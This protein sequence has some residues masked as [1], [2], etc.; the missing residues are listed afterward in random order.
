MSFKVL[1]NKSEI[2]TSRHILKSRKISSLSPWIVRYLSKYNITKLI[3]IG[4]INKS[5]DILQT[6][7]FIEKNCSKKA[8]ILDLGAFGSEILSVL[9]NLNYLSLTGIDMNKQISK[10]PNN[11]NITYTCENYL[12]SSFEDDSFDVV[13]AISAIEHGFDGDRL[14][15]EIS[16]ILRPGGFFISSFDYWPDKLD[17][18]GLTIFN[19]EWTIFSKDEVI[20]FIN[21]S[22]KYNFIPYGE[23]YYEAGEKVIHWGGKEYTFG[24][25]ALLK[26]N[27][28]FS[29]KL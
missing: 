6:V 22:L 15:K 19:M 27:S 4:D 23:L 2:I 28:H 8:K 5:W 21:S 20:D 18:S 13:I 17:T 16:R 12:S 7:N 10:M 25:L 14:L 3:A 29:W 9:F 24:W 1:Q 26:S 11:K